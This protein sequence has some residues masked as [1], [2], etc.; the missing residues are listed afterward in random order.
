VASSK[1][2]QAS[3][4]MSA[5]VEYLAPRSTYITFS[6]SGLLMAPVYIHHSSMLS[7]LEAQHG[8]KHSQGCHLSEYRKVSASAH[9]I[10]SVR[11]DIILSK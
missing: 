3:D 10:A 9:V 1:T 2:M 4:H 7:L 8:I 6:R 11:C 5:G